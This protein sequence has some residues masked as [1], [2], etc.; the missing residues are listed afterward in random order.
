MTD[1]LK[2][3]KALL[4]KAESTTN[5]HEADALQRKAEELMVK[6]GIDDAAL[7]SASGADRVSANVIERRMQFTGIYAD[8][9]C[10]FFGP[11]IVR[12]VAGD[13]IKL[14]NGVKGS[15]YLIGMKS[16]VDRAVVLIESLEAQAMHAM[17]EWW[18]TVSD[19]HK[20]IVGGSG[21]YRDRRS[22]L[23]GFGGRVKER[24]T[25]LRHVE[26]TSVSNALVVR[27]ETVEAAYRKMYPV[28][29]K[30]RSSKITGSYGG[31]VAGRV[32]GN[33]AGLAT[34]AISR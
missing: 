2:R 25:E 22:F 34:E 18:K 23:L 11:Y 1:Y 28:T 15:L 6:W 24:L 19:E 13:N 26:E 4:A 20:A 31:M 29:G 5:E 7:E 16:D 14:L 3:I 17:R 27:K 8:A 9:M 12:G 10:K 21:G 32:A 33:S 30:A